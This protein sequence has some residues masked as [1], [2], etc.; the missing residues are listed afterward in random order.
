M[1]GALSSAS[2]QP[3]TFD[4]PAA[5]LPRLTGADSCQKLGAIPQGVPPIFV[6]AR[7]LDQL[8]QISDEYPDFEVGGFL[9]GGVFRDPEHQTLFVEIHEYVQATSLLSQ[10]HSLTFTHDTWAAVHRQ[11]EQKFPE[12][13]IVGW[14]HTHPGFGIFLSRQDEF[15]HR[16]FFQQPWQ[17]ALVVD[18][19]QGELGFFQ[20]RQGQIV[21]TGFFVVPAAQ[22]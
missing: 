6:H 10:H 4:A 11:M 21:D 20:W 18:P 16:H 5:S 19:R 1:N 13:Q 17:V 9:L 2:A 15:I 7:V 12:Q 14:H 8:L 22:G 3:A